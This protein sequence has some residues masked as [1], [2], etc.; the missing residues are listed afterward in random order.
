M[1]FE[2]H[3]SL[4]LLRNRAREIRDEVSESR[5]VRSSGRRRRGSR[6]VTPKDDTQS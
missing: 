4:I 3:R 5:S 1:L 2:L 6:S